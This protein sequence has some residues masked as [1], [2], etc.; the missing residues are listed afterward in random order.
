[1]VLGCQE[2]ERRDQRRGLAIWQHCHASPK[3]ETILLSQEE[4]DIKHKI[5]IWIIK[6]N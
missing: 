6:M 4:E 5:N 3:K 2:P 1:V